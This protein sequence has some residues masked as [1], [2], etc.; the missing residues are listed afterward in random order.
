MKPEISELRKL[1]PL[2]IERLADIAYDLWWASSHEARSVFRKI[3]RH[4]WWRSDH[5]PIVLLQRIP[6]RRLDE[7]A[8][9]AEF[10]QAYD[11]LLAFYDIDCQRSTKWYESEIRNFDSGPIAYFSAEYGLHSSL[12]IYSGGLGVLAGDHVK[13]ADDLGIPIVAVGFLYPYGYFEQ[14]IT[15]SGVQDANYRKL[16]PSSTVLQHV[17][18]KDGKPLI[19]TINHR[20][21]NGALHLRIWQ[22]KLGTITIYLMDSDVE[23]NDPED[24]D[25]TRRLYGGDKL[26]RLRQEIALGIGGVKTFQALGISPKVW[27]ANEGHSAFMFIERLRLE[28]QTG[29]SFSEAVKHIR[30]TSVFTTH[31]PVPAGHDA[32]DEKMVVEHFEQTIAELG[33]SN[34]DFLSL[35]RHNGEFNM[36]AL[37]MTMSDKRNAVSKKHEEVTRE[38]WPGYETPERP[39]TSVTNGVHVAT[40]LAPEF[41]DLFHL[42]LPSDWRNY[43]TDKDYWQQI[44]SIPDQL[45]WHVRQELARH[46]GR[47]IGDLLRKR[48][49][50]SDADL[51]IRGA[52]YNPAALTLCFARRFAT[53]KRAD[54]LFHNPDRLAR[55]L[56]DARH[57]VQIIYSGK[58]HPADEGGKSMIKEIWEF[59]KDPIFRGKVMFIEDYSMHTAKTLVQGSDVWLNLPR[60]PLEASGTSGMKAG[61]NGVPNLSV[62]DGWWMESYN[63]RNGWAIASNDKLDKTE[64]DDSDAEQLYR[65][66]ETEIV[67]LYYDRN[68]DNMPIEWLK[69]IKESIATVLPIFS[70]ERMMKEY[71]N[72]LYLPSL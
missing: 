15:A 2:R 10:L 20:Q 8:V 11:G 48:P 5:N 35:G 23:A 21:N 18:D 34:E 26:Y 53:Y 67:P 61:M 47:Y 31:T 3:S 28:M 6:R 44:H 32:F 7:L 70:S 52:L 27:H 43:L 55:I 72:G 16:D 42:T 45:L 65:L 51:V 17:Y 40:W 13:T 25:L 14:Q 46:L 71:V 38:M 29:K 63:G 49:M 50:E 4:D 9:N 66:L 24:S 58:A 57:P 12:P 54:L 59:A 64:Q 37:A 68:L 36:T 69:V 1:L 62:L 30:S 56:N 41:D 33:I 39:I 19:I 22:V 60:A